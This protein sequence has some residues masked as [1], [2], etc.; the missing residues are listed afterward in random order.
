MTLKGR[1][2]KPKDTIERS[3]QASQATFL[4]LIAWF[5]TS[6]S[7]FRAGQCSSSPLPVGARLC[8]LQS[9]RLADVPVL[10]KSLSRLG[11]FDF[12]RGCTVP[13]GGA[14]CPFMLLQVLIQAAE[15]K[16]VAGLGRLARCWCS[17]LPL[18]CTEKPNSFS[19]RSSRLDRVHPRC[20]RESC[21]CGMCSLPTNKWRP[22]RSQYSLHRP[23]CKAS[24]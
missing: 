24:Q 14:A 8:L 18:D 5:L 15:T 2:L 13:T 7:R 10:N 11:V 22:Q 1:E 20:T 16:L 23:A 3:Q 19:H 21:T 17:R 6:L 4:S 9:S 12:A